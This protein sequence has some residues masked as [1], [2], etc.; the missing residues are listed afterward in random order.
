MVKGRVMLSL[1][2]LV[3]IFFV[4]ISASLSREFGGLDGLEPDISPDISCDERMAAINAYKR[5]ADERASLPSDEQV[6]GWLK[7]FW[8]ST[9]GPYWSDFT[10]D[11]EGPWYCWPGIEI[12]DDNGTITFNMFMVAN[13]I[14]GTLPE[15]FGYIPISYVG[16]GE[17]HI[18]GT[19]P[20]SICESETM[21][22][23]VTQNNPIEGTI[24]DCI[25][26][27]GAP[28]YSISMGSNRL[29]GS[30]PESL[31]NATSLHY[32]LLN[33]NKLSGTLSESIANLGAL[34][35]LDLSN[36]TLSGSLPKGMGYAF[37]LSQVYLGH[38]N[39]SG[40]ISSESFRGPS[41]LAGSHLNISKMIL[42]NNHFEGP[43]L[44]FGKLAHIS[45][46][47]I[48]HNHF[49]QPIPRL[50]YL[51]KLAYL[52]FSYNNISSRIDPDDLLMFRVA[53]LSYYSGVGN[54]LVFQAEG[55]IWHSQYPFRFTGDTQLKTSAEDWTC[56]LITIS[57]T[58]LTF[59][60]DPGF[61]NYSHCTC[62]RGYYGTPPD[63]CFPCPINAEHCPNGIELSVP[64]SQY[65]YPI[66]LEP[67]H[68]HPSSVASSKALLLPK[69][70]ETR[71]LLDSFW[72]RLWRALQGIE[73]EDL[74]LD[75]ESPLPDDGLDSSE[76][77]Q[78]GIFSRN[79]EPDGLAPESHLL[80]GNFQPVF[81]E[82]CYYE[83][84][85]ANICHIKLWTDEENQ[86]HPY[87]DAP[88]GVSPQE[89]KC[90]VGYTGRQCSK[91]LCDVDKDPNTCYYQ[92]SKC[93]KCSSVW[94]GNQTA[95]LAICAIILLFI[96]TSV[97]H[98]LMLRA[99]RRYRDRSLENASVIK[100]GFYRILHVRTI[101][102]FKLFLIWIQTLSAIVDWPSNAL[103]R[104]WSLIEIA[105]GN[106]AGM[107]TT[108]L[109][110]TLRLPVVSFLAKSFAPIILIAILSLSIVVAH[111]VWLLFFRPKN[112][113]TYLLV[114]AEQRKE[115]FY[116]EYT[117]TL[118]QEPPGS[119]SKTNGNGTAWSSWETSE[120]E[121][122]LVKGP[123]SMTD[124]ELEKIES[125]SYSDHPGARLLGT[126][127]SDLGDLS[128]EANAEDFKSLVL[129]GGVRYFSARALVVSEI[130]AVLYFFYFG[131]T[132]SS[133][134]FFT[135][136]SQKG[137]GDL[138]VR[139][140]PWIRCDGRQAKDLR[141]SSIPFFVIITAGAPI[142]FAS[143]LFYYR[144]QLHKRTVTDIIGGL[145]RCYRKEMFWWELVVLARRL[146]LAL[147]LRIEK[148]SAFHQWSVILVLTISVVLQ[149]SFQPFNQRGENRAEE[150]SLL[151]LILTYVAQEGARAAS[152]QIKSIFW[153]SFFL[154]CLFMAITLA[155][156]IRSWCTGSVKV[157]D[158]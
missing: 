31:Y 128:V 127:D 28:W 49:T 152:M 143:L 6:E 94:S 103:H 23:F 108:C 107:G 126:N 42:T 150:L 21:S 122:D 84:A 104:I 52:D 13:N 40:T 82:P 125:E 33:G 97:V 29:T 30:I 66:E 3:L 45:V 51:P 101:G 18:S 92:S 96:I 56:Q 118:Q 50:R 55:S 26:S 19:L 34:M 36:N 151:L 60:V 25:G 115:T 112:F 37:N 111:S 155:L 17:N 78:S 27:Y 59:L 156:L 81:F 121:A 35:V 53:D 72:T 158:E 139:S 2:G 4:L 62:I 67:H 54:D 119:T 63:H 70:S 149:F 98:V 142:L 71:A 20:R 11:F 110:P 75:S 38:N 9:G 133:L 100:R 44:V 83:G 57:D 114:P 138:F 136:S 137:T 8:N 1:G 43:M 7:E 24:P 86:V 65:P 129:E 5:Q 46:L 123:S 154:N 153:V 120:S 48:A 134:S 99:K 146:V 117:A 106:P 135:C 61:L 15:S 58:G 12:D 131:V 87:W 85:C 145:Y 16:L 109:W 77:D 73:D 148:Q 116:P 39:F 130:L 79:F 132:L 80:P 105:N 10:W 41:D 89:C 141:M 32:I 102:Y 74:V 68:D 144:N 95:A 147:V 113:K 140:M 91:C 90:T 93:R 47:N 88:L 124:D 14:T 69:V 64:F 157:D 76:K 22:S